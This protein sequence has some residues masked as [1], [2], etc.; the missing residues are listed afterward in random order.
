MFPNHEDLILKQPSTLAAIER[1]TATLGFDMPSILE[2]G[3]LLRYLAASKRNAKLLEL[4]TGTGIATCWLLDGMDQSSQLITIDNDA[5]VLEV[6]R[7]QL[8]N[9]SRLIII[10]EDAAIYLERAS[11]NYFDLIFADAWPGKFTHLDQ[12]LSLLAEDGIYIVDDLLPQPSW[13]EYH[14]PRIP[15]FIENL[16][17]RLELEVEYWEWASGILIARRYS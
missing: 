8:G 4:G 9:D 11:Q 3:A 16:R 14:A 2:T 17:S 6:A 1:D 13:P 10:N 5:E 7:R 12:A 15:V